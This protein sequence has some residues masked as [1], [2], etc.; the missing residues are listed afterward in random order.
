MVTFAIVS[1]VR[2]DRWAAVL[3]APHLTCLLYAT[4]L[5]IAIARFNQVGIHGRD[6]KCRELLRRL[7]ASSALLPAAWPTLVS[8]PHRMRPG[9]RTEGGVHRDDL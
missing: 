3:L 4:A 6:A 5:N 8:V 2:I 1:A 9:N 7:L